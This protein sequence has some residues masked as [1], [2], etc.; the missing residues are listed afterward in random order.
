MGGLLSLSGSWSWG[1]QQLGSGLFY[2]VINRETHGLD[3]K[4]GGGGLRFLPDVR[5]SPLSLGAEWLRWSRQWRAGVQECLCEPEN[6]PLKTLSRCKW[7]SFKSN[8]KNKLGAYR[9][10]LVIIG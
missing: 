6:R 8:K 5:R 1:T 2:S 3:L 9:S 10:G 7:Q 4:A